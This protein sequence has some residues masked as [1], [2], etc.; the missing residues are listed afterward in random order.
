MKKWSFINAARSMEQRVECISD[1]AERCIFYANGWQ[2]SLAVNNARGNVQIAK[3]AHLFAAV[4]NRL[5]K[6]LELREKATIALPKVGR[7]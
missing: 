6:V 4:W 5:R 7:K 3:R 1:G 2:F